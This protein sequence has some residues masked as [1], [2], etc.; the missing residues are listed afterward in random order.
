VLLA[1]ESG[2]AWADVDER[3]A[4]ILCYTSG[5]T[6]DPKGVLFSH[7]STVLHAMNGC[8]VDAFGIS[9]RDVVMPVVPMFH[10]N[11]WGMPFMCAMTGAKQVMVGQDMAA[12]RLVDIAQTEGVTFSAGVPTV[13]LAVR[14]ELVASGRE[15]KAL[16][17]VIVAGSA[18]PQ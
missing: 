17:R 8:L 9:A 2:D 5:T 14:D 10:A 13:W 1:S 16:N 4:A 18:M 15:L 6:G 11:C 3:A 7:R 12:K